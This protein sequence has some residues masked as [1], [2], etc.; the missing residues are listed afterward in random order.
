M[1]RM[2]L[3]TLLILA[4]GG[5]QGPYV[6]SGYGSY[7]G[8]GGGTRDGAHGGIDYPDTEGAPVLAAANGKVQRL[9]NS[10]G[11]GYG[12]AISHEQ[13]SSLL[14][15]HFLYTTYCHL[16]DWAKIAL[17]NGQVRR[18]DVIGYVG[19]TGNSMG[20]PHVHF[21]LNTDGRSHASGDLEG[22]EDPAKYLVGCFDPKKTYLPDQLT[23]PVACS[24]K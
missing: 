15:K 3:T 4:L 14:G 1:K 17:D 19:T 7:V 23:H 6:A 16:D 18:G 21:E 9:F 11:C 2:S 12:V 10:G 8:V 20:V 24:N 13:L 22:T 5:C